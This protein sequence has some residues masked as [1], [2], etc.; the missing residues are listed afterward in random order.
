VVKFLN[1]LFRNPSDADGQAGESGRIHDR[2]HDLVLRYVVYV[3][4]IFILENGASEIADCFDDFQV[5]VNPKQPYS[6]NSDSADKNVL[7]V[8]INNTAM[9]R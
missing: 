1:H 4:Q 2:F 7:D 6:K 9:N 8:N 3:N 5:E